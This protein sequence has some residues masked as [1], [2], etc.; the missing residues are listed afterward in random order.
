MI[1]MGVDGQFSVH[2]S[3]FDEWEREQGVGG[4]DKCGHVN[5]RVLLV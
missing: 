3:N 5:Q 2:Y 4:I 1:G